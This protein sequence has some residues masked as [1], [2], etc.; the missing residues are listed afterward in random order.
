VR[1]HADATIA[2]DR[3]LRGVMSVEIEWLVWLLAGAAAALLALVSSLAVGNAYLRRVRTQLPQPA[4]AATSPVLRA[5]E[6]SGAA[7]MTPLIDASRPTAVSVPAGSGPPISSHLSPGSAVIGYVTVAGD[8]GAG[9]AFDSSRAIE[10]MCERSAWELLETVRDPDQGPTL[11]R[12]GLR[13]ALERITSGVAQGLIVNDL[14]RISRSIVDLGALMAWF[15]DA[16]ATLIALDLDIDTSTPE[17]RHVANTLIALS[18]RDHQRIASGTRRGLAKG[19]ASGRPN[20]RPAVSHRPELVERIVAMRAAKMTL[21]AIADQFNAEGVPTLRGGK[22][23]RPSSI[24]AALGY[25]RPG[26]RDHLP[27]PD[28]RGRL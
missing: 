4:S 19:R 20:G 25:R 26:P 27:S 22:K 17:G 14:Q 16:D 2:V 15:R 8:H 21:R 12:P 18:A 9:S 24:Q 1:A 6:A 11:D 5:A 3:Q 7:A 28:A 23:W 13:Y 10:T